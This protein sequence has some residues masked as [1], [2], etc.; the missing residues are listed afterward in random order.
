M[1]AADKII[2][3][4][5]RVHNIKNADV[6]IPLNTFTVLTGVSGSGKSSLA[7]DTLYAEGQRRYIESF[8]PYARQFLEKIQQPDVEQIDGIFPAIAISQRPQ[9]SNPRST[10]GTITEIYDYL[11]LLFAKIGEIHCYSCG[12][13]EKKK[14]ISY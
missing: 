7:L 5:V 3:R 12:R 13:R 11:R 9:A 6:D 4:G 14:H 2:L 10:V 1:N 8:S